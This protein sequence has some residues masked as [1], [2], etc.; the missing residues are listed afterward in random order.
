MIPTRPDRGMREGE[1]IAF[2]SCAM[3]LSAL[4]V[5]LILPAFGEMRPV[6]GL[7][8]DSNRLAGTITSYILGVSVGT[9]VYGPWSDRFGRKRALR[10]GFTVYVIGAL[11][12][13]T[14]VAAGSLTA[15]FAAQFLWGVGASG[16]RV[17]ALAIVRDLY[18]GDRMARIMSSVFAVFTIV[19]VFAPLAGSVVVRFLSWPG[20]FWLAAG[21]AAPVALWGARLGETWKGASPVG[22]RVSGLAST[23]SRI[24][25]RRSTVLYTVAMTGSFGAFFSYMASSELLLS[26]V[27]ARRHLF[28]WI[29]GGVTGLMSLAMFANAA[30]VE[31]L[32]TR[33]VLLGT[34]VIYLAA[35]TA[36][37]VGVGSAFGRPTLAFFVVCLSIIAAMHGLVVTNLNSLVLDPMGDHAGT[38]GSIIGTISTGGGAL[39]GSLI[40][41]A[42]DGTVTPLAIGFVTVSATGLALCVLAG[43]AEGDEPDSATGDPGC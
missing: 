14:S 39:I 17:V 22:S 13:L 36:L 38:A 12:A 28:P 35:A 10:A 7:A 37:A 24:L 34:L 25:R 5:G 4:G 26:D 23:V 16:P 30:L 32:T 1:V 40:D 31:K 6:L 8:E 20:V 15:L 11:G 33:R 2:L 42:Y 9:L 19:P 29:Y 18:S 43:R 27:F 3:G 41:R 21:L